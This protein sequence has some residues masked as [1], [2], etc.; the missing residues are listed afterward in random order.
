[1]KET[2]KNIL[3]YLLGKPEGLEGTRTPQNVSMEFSVHYPYLKQ[4]IDVARLI[5]NSGTWTFVYTPTFKSQ[6]EVP[7]ITDFPDKNEV[8]TS[9]ELWSFFTERI[10]NMDQKSVREII[11]SKEIDE[12]DIAVL[13]SFFGGRTITNNFVVQPK[14]LNTSTLVHA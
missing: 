6:S 11:N 13:L 2:V 3:G 12:T 5:L 4:N 7:P 10:P 8:Y 14:Q 1:M 9:P